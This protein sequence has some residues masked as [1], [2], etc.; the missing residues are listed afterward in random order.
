M[1][2]QVVTSSIVFVICLLYASIFLKVHAQPST[3]LDS[4][5]KTTQKSEI[6]GSYNYSQTVADKNHKMNKGANSDENIM[7]QPGKDFD[8]LMK[9]NSFPCDCIP[10]SPLSKTGMIEKQYVDLIHHIVEGAEGNLDNLNQED[11]ERIEKAFRCWFLSSVICNLEDATTVKDMQN[12]TGE[13]LRWIKMAETLYS[14]LVNIDEQLLGE[15]ETKGRQ[16]VIKGLKV[17]VTTEEKGCC[18][19]RSADIRLQHYEN[20]IILQRFIDLLG[21]SE[22]ENFA[23]AFSYTEILCGEVKIQPT[24]HAVMLGESIEFALTGEGA[25]GNSFSHWDIVDKFK[26]TTEPPGIIEV[27]GNKNTVAVTGVSPGEAKLSVQASLETNWESNVFCAKSY[28]ATVTVAAPSSVEVIL[29]FDSVQC[30]QSLTASA[31]AKDNQDNPLEVS[32]FIWSSSN[33]IIATVIEGVVSGHTPGEATITAE[34]WG[35]AGSADICVTAP[36]FIVVTPSTGL[37]DCGR[38]IQLSAILT[39]ASAD[40]LECSGVTWS[41]SDESIA[42]VNEG[43]VTAIN[44]GNVTITAEL[45]DVSGSADISVTAPDFIVVTPS[46]G[47]IDCGRT[48]QLILQDDHEEPLECFGVT[49]SSSDDT[50]ASVIEG[51]VSGHTPGEVTITADLGDVSGSADIRVRPPATIVV[52]PSTD[53][54]EAGLTTQLTATLQDAHGRN[55][56]CSGVTWSSSDESI[57]TVVDGLVTALSL[58]EV[59]ITAQIGTVSGTSDIS[60]FAAKW[61]RLYGGRG[62]TC[63]YSVQQISGGGYIL[64][65]YVNLEHYNQLHDNYFNCP[66]VAKLRSN[67]SI[68]WT[69]GYWVDLSTN[70]LSLDKTLDGGY[71]IAGD[72]GWPTKIWVIKLDSIGSVTWRKAYGN[73]GVRAQS[74]KQ[75]S[76]GGYVIAGLYSFGAVGGNPWVIKLDSGGN[77]EWQ[78]AQNALSQCNRI[79]IQETSDAGYIVVAGSLI[80]R[81][82]ATGTL[83]WRKGAPA[84]EAVAVTPDGGF[85]TGGS[86]LAMKFDQDG[87]IQYQKI[88]DDG[89]NYERIYSV[90]VTSDGGYIVAGEIYFPVPENYSSDFWVCKLHNDLSIGWQ[91]RYDISKWD[92]ALMVEQASDGGYIVAGR[93]GPFEEN[94]YKACLLK[95]D[96]DGRPIYVNNAQNIFLGQATN[97]VA[98]NATHETWEYVYTLFETTASE[99]NMDFFRFEDPQL[100]VETIYPR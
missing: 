10:D 7:A 33:E 61:V 97:C 24:P 68:I 12:A 14:I 71:I 94:G 96:E 36:D 87:N 84:S 57:A 47:L 51:V 50:I 44:L 32:G 15:M 81:L 99:S 53:S 30:G 35:V 18:F 39:D 26:W 48:L 98:S 42:S 75:T 100:T 89:S 45:G 31:V 77:I 66:L 85:V 72:S 91:K 70:T 92:R 13:F 67:G 93:A 1:T 59:R 95:L 43:L 55:L 73:G 40:A 78:R 27:Q 37:I 25:S 83:L 38:T 79:E 90:A 16:A 17:L 88:Y 62:D 82:T 28:T 52:T 74:I 63:A 22:L 56:E 21:W 5:Y 20:I 60:I 54:I 80:L 34:L 19:S 69:N 76:D 64:Q 3:D 65:G 11:I 6:E 4:C 86:A 46:T 49:W 41:S 9:K 58:G 2:K 23:A 29:P 8:E